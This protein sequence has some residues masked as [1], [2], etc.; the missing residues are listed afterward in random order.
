MPLDLVDAVALIGPQE[1]IRERMGR[2]AAAGVTTLTVNPVGAVGEEREAIV[3]T[4]A[5]LIADL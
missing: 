2:Y 3:R 4:I 5:R 1:R